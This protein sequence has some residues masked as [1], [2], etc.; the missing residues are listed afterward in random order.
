M[1]SDS[2]L[3]P[4]APKPTP[5]VSGLDSLRSPLFETKVPLAAPT[6]PPTEDLL[7]QIRALLEQSQLTNASAVAEFEQRAAA[8]LG[9]PD[10]VAVSSCTSG[11]M[12]VERLLGL[13][14]EVILPSFTFF[15]TGHGLLWNGL[16]P[17][18]VDCD[19]ETFNID[20]E[21]I[22]AAI[23]PR[24][25]AILA[26][27]IFGCP[28]PVRHLKDIAARHGLRL[29]FDGAHAFGSQLDGTNVVEWGDATVFSLTPTKPLV[30]GE[31]GLIV[32]HDPDLAQ[33]LRQARNYGKGQT[34]DC[35]ILGL[36]AR[37]TEIQ[38][39][40]GTAGLAYVE[41]GIKRRNEVAEVYQRKF[42][43]VDGLTPQRIGP[44]VR[45]SRK[46]F[47]VLIDEQRFGV[48][49]VQ[50][51]DALARDRVETRR[52]FDPPLHRQKLYRTFYRPESN[53]LPLTDRIS[54]RVL[55]LPIYAGLA[56]D[57]VEAIAERV[58][59]IGRGAGQPGRKPLPSSTPVPAAY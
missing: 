52:Y 3:Q 37:M 54:S 6:L 29:I 25:S 16:E 10:A 1:T 20:P 35:E 18:F 28:V 27:H 26:V 21:R 40:L 49:R 58:V 9:A 11:L 23:T 56:N 50:L 47:A 43:D 57:T 44:A 41:W 17:V 34:Y 14:G 5:V 15:A 38:A 45:S 32:T 19:P 53:P 36:N 30:A 46:D 4:R 12:L 51:E 55:C 13:S 33:R 24:T 42:H 48:S 39:V 31:G 7:E 22:E 8:Y 2:V 59:R